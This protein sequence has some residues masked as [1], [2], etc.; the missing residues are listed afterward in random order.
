MNK[1]STIERIYALGN[2]QNIKITDTITEIPDTVLEDNLLMDGIISLQLVNTELTYRRYL[3]M[4]ESL[5]EGTTNDKLA[6]ILQNFRDTTYNQF[7]A[8]LNQK[9]EI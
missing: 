3:S 1:T 6:D 9:Q 2:Y 7:L 4:L 8:Q 5:P